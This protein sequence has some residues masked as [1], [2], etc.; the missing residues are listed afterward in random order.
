MTPESRGPPG[1]GLS[2]MTLRRVSGGVGLGSLGKLPGPI[3]TP[4]RKSV[5]SGSHPGVGFAI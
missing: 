3:P 2:G 5:D 4:D 1:P